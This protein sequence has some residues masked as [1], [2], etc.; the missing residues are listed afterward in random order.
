MAPKLPTAFVSYSW[1]D[2]S[3]KAWVRLLAR[4][5][6]GDGVDVTLDQWHTAPGDQL[7]A[8]MEHAIRTNEYVLIVCSPGY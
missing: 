8:F 1:D 4:R 7:P 2:E 5:L 3:N 6:R